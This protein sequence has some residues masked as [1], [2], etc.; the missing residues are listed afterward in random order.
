MARRKAAQSTTTW[1]RLEALEPRLLLNGDGV[2]DIDQGLPDLQVLFRDTI[3][4]PDD[5]LT[6]GGKRLTL[7]LDILNVD[8][9]GP[10]QVTLPV[11]R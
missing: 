4:L 3:K 10:D 5:Y 7:P 1:R 11:A 6:G 9:A 2:I 8:T